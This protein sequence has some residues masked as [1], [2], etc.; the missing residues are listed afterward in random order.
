MDPPPNIQPCM[1]FSKQAS[2]SHH[3]FPTTATVVLDRRYGVGSD[4]TAEVNVPEVTS[5][6]EVTAPEVTSYPTFP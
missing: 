3:G 4:V 6:P 5:Q 1:K 2:G